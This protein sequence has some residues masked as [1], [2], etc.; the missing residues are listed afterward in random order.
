MAPMRPSAPADDEP[1]SGV[2]R[3]RW[4]RPVWLVAGGMALVLGLVGVALP[5]LPTTPF[6]LLAAFCFARGSRRWEHWLLHHPRWGPMVRNWRDHH[7]VPLGAKRLATVMMAGSS[8]WAAWTISSGW[9]WVPAL[10]CAAVAAW[11]WRLPSR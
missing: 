4:M 9:R 7:A 6:I 8:A 3:S 11:L 1:E 10:C 5:L 2:S